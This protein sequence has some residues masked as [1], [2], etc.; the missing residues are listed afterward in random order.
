MSGLLVC[1]KTVSSFIKVSCQHVYSE[2]L[3]VT[4]T[5]SRH[6]SYISK[7][8]LFLHVCLRT[9]RHQ[10]QCHECLYQV[11]CLRTARFSLIIQW[12]YRHS[13]CLHLST[14]CYVQQSISLQRTPPSTNP[15]LSFPFPV[16]ERRRRKIIRINSSSPKS[17]SS[18]RRNAGLAIELTKSPTIWF[19][20][21]N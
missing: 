5:L 4:G 10:W 21:E 12:Q 16:G 7:T 2:M 18:P 15:A 3:S 14:S 8:V 9:V 11:V 13:P 19:A 1:L 17:L 6:P 20:R